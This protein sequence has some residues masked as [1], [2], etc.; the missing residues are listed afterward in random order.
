MALEPN[1]DRLDLL[2][3]KSLKVRAGTRA[4]SLNKNLS[5]YIRDLIRADV[6]QAEMVEQGYEYNGGIVVGYQ[7]SGDGDR[8][9]QALST[10]GSEGVA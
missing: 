3:P 9:V 1:N 10:L 2:L 7:F 5:T 4:D 8:T 6:T